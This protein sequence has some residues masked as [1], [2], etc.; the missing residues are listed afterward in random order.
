MEVVF[1]TI[2]G[3]KIAVREAVAEEENCRLSPRALL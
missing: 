1:L 3:D 2:G